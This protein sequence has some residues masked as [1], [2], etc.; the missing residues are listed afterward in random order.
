[1]IFSFPECAGLEE[2][3]GTAGGGGS[4]SLSTRDLPEGIDVTATAES[5][6]AFAAFWVRYLG[7]LS[8]LSRSGL[9]AG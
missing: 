6:N 8:S 7:D 4:V 9:F 2:L 1:M 3:T 5:V